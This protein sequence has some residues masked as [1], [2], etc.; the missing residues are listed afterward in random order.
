MHHA[1]GRIPHGSLIQHPGQQLSFFNN[2]LNN[3]PKPFRLSKKG[4][5]LYIWGH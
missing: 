5:P 1:S 3:T 4:F 2:D